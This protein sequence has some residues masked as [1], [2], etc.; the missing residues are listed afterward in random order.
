MSAKILI[1]EDDFYFAQNL[2]LMLRQMGFEV[3]GKA[4]NGET[5]LQLA[6]QTQPDAILMDIELAGAMNGIDVAEQLQARGDFP[7]IF[8]TAHANVEILNRLERLRTYGYLLKPSKDWQIRTTIELALSS[9]ALEQKLRRNLV[10]QQAIAHCSTVLVQ[11]ITSDQERETVFREVA[12][13]LLEGTKVSQIT[14]AMNTVDA[15]GNLSGIVICEVA[16]PEWQASLDQGTALL[17]A[18]FASP[19]Y[20]ARLE[21]GQECSGTV[22]ELFPDL[23]A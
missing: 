14:L 1:V 23:T 9:F 7:I 4:E 10:L 8:L 3:V 2:E 13:I 19:V 17:N 21:Q 15:T 11:P 6:K 22:A 5:A 12:Q 16:Q 20:S 18:L